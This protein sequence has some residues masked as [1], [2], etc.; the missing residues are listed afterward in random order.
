VAARTTGRTACTVILSLKL[1]F[2]SSNLNV[3]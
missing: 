2:C 3:S 1:A